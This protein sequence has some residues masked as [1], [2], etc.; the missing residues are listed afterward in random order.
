MRKIDYIIIH[1]SATKSNIRFDA[2]QCREYHVYVRHYDD[3][4]YHWYVERDGR[5]VKGRPEGIA[6]AHCINHN[7]NSIG[8]CYEGGLEAPSD[9]PKGGEISDTTTNGKQNDSSINRSSLREGLGRLVPADTR[10]PEQKASLLK[11]LKQLKQRYPNA[12]I[13]GHRDFNSHKNCPCFDARSEY[14]GL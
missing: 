11:L 7:Y 3:I 9:S 12:K 1:C 8:V 6:G 14:A 5:I 4:G 10:T 13:V 2:E